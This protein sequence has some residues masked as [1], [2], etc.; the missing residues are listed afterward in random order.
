MAAPPRTG[1]TPVRRNADVAPAPDEST[2]LDGTLAA[3]LERTS[4]LAATVLQAPAA[5]IALVG[6]DRRC[7]GGGS[8]LPAWFFHDQG[9]LIRS[10]LGTRI[11]DA[12]GVVT[13]TDARGRSPVRHNGSWHESE[14]AERL[15]IASYMGAPLTGDDGELLGIFCVTDVIPRA[16]SAREISILTD[17]AASA[18]TELAL[19]HRIIQRERIERQL[20]HASRHDPLTGLPNR[21]FFTERLA[22]AVSRARGAQGHLFAL[23]FLDLDHFKV[24]NDSVGHHAGDELLV[25][26]ARRLEGCLRGGDMVARLGGDEFALLLE[27][28]QDGSDAAHVAERIQATL[29]APVNVGGYDVFTTASLG[30]VLSSSAHEQPEHLLRSADMAMYRAKMSG[31]ARF[32]IFDPAMHA[33][34][35]IRLQLE[36]DLRRAVERREFDLHFQP[37]VHLASGTITGVEAL[38]RWRHPQRGMIQPDSFI[39]EA[40]ET[41]LIIPIGLWVLE[42]ACRQLRRWDDLP[43]VRASRNGGAGGNHEERAPELSIAV[44]IAGRQL[45]QQE[46]LRSVE[47]TLVQNGVHPTRLRLEITESAILDKPEPVV[48]MLHEMKD[49]GVQI[50]LDDFGT[51]Y[52]SLSYLHQLPLDALKIDRAFV[53]Q[54]ESSE[55]TFQLVQ[56]ILQMSANLGLEAIAEGVTTVEQMRR[57]RSLHCGYAQGYL[58]SAPLDSEAM[59][60][61]L[62]SRPSW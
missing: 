12:N 35:L 15:G 16:W 46:L 43:E 59:T 41:G 20:R 8:E 7:F 28:V 33:A 58:F 5:F 45:I 52:S 62:R 48:R 49:L 31:R 2:A 39:A 32:E 36:T 51:G 1:A 54:I 22:Q 9:V 27:R 18:S 60:A 23:I 24:V 47:R 17:L 26:V 11:G 40:E 25:A 10:G 57:L 19:R 37:V 50:F 6:S 29:S 56:T 3:S 30:I 13:V 44:N 14:I 61:L 38:L 55:R 53:S 21:S 34:A 4:R 42:E